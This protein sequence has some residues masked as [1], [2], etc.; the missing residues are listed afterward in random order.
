M[1]SSFVPLQAVADPR[2][3]FSA[4][5]LNQIVSLV[6]LRDTG[7]AREIPVFGF[8]D[9][10]FVMGV[11]DEVEKRPLPTPEVVKV[12]KNEE[13]S[14]KEVKITDFF[15]SKSPTVMKPTHGFYLVDSKTRG[16]PVLPKP[17]YTVAVCVGYLYIY[18]P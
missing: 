7:K 4:R 9:D 8:F 10:D 17:E 15:K 1:S 5:L 18:K 14:Q 12:S 2:S 11:M 13:A 6:T 16:A 3:L